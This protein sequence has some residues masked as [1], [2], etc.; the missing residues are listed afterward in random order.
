[1]P[2]WPA[3]QLVGEVR[4]VEVRRA[5]RDVEH[6]DVVRGRGHLGGGEGGG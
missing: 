5:A 2:R 4:K 3:R 1:M 6:G